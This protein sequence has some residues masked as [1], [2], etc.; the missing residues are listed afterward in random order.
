MSED[1][2]ETIALLRQALASFEAGGDPVPY[3]AGHGLQSRRLR[4]EWEEPALSIDL[5]LPIDRVLSDEDT[6]A[7]DAADAAAALRMALLLLTAAEEGLLA[8]EGEARLAVAHDGET[9]SWASYAPDGELLAD[10]D[11]WA[12]LV[13]RLEAA[14]HDTSDSPAVTVIWP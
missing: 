12:P 8:V 3:V 10:G 2:A 14:F 9:A 5:D 11:D 4:F 7:A 1:R 13:A 6:Q